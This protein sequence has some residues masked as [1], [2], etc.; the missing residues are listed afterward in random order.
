M[1]RLRGWLVI[2]SFMRY[3]LEADYFRGESHIAI[4]LHDL[5]FD[6]ATLVADAYQ[7]YQIRLDRVV[8][9]ELPRAP[10]VLRKFIQDWRVDG[11]WQDVAYDVELAFD[12][13]SFE[14]QRGGDDLPPFW[15]SRDQREI[16]MQLSPDRWKLVQVFL[17]ERGLPEDLFY[18]EDQRVCVSWT[19]KTMVGRF[20]HR[21][22]FTAQR[23]YS[24]RQ[25][26]REQGRCK[27]G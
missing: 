1:R 3:R 11:R 12:H 25:W 22:G 21:L 5:A 10:E 23:C 27:A 15:Y 26:T 2:S 19:P 9:G 13:A 20:F 17:L 16:Q 8:R 7:F 6:L 4:A 14:G 24:P 18:R